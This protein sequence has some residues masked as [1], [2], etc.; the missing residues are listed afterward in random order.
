MNACAWESTRPYYIPAG[1]TDCRRQDLAIYYIS[2][3]RLCSAGIREEQHLPIGHIDSPARGRSRRLPPRLI[4]YSVYR[5]NWLPIISL[6]TLSHIPP[7]YH[8]QSSQFFSLIVMGEEVKKVNTNN[9]M[10]I[11][12]LFPNYAYY[13]LGWLFDP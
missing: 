10:N 9:T 5:P 12:Q 1:H 8:Y 2:L 7:A 4:S 13:E 3:H 6:R 11:A